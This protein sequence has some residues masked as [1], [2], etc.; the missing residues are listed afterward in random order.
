M[1][2]AKA[3]RAREYLYGWDTEANRLTVAALPRSPAPCPPSPTSPPPAKSS[4]A[5]PTP[6]PP[7]ASSPS[8]PPPLPTPTPTAPQLPPVVWR[9]GTR[10]NAPHLLAVGGPASGKTTLL[11]T[12]AVQ[13][14]RDGDVLAVDATGSGDFACLAGRAGVLRVETTQNGAREAL[15]WLR[16]ETARR[17]A[18]IAEAKRSGRAAPEDARRPLC[19]LLD[20]PAD[21]ADPDVHTLLDL[22][23]RLG[24]TTHISIV[25]TARPAQ[26]DRLHPGLLSETH[27]RVA[28]G[29]P[30]CRHPRRRPRL[31]P[32]HRRRRRRPRRPRIRPRRRRPRHPPADP[33]HPR[34]PRRRH[35]GRRPHPRPGPPAPGRGTRR[36]AGTRDRDGSHGDRTVAGEDDLTKTPS[37]ASATAPGRRHRGAPAD[38]TRST[39]APRCPR[40]RAGWNPHAIDGTAPTVVGPA[41]C[42]CAVRTSSDGDTGKPRRRLPPA[43]GAR[44]PAPPPPARR[45]GRADTRCGGGRWLRAC[46]RG[47]AGP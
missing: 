45:S 24:R 18:A 3:G 37:G 36:A 12:I 31:R 26:L 17:A 41:F 8:P 35:P 14:L 30:R 44:R 32:R 16:E 10:T 2:E 39:G 29:P 20:E 40:G 46:P 47:A 42:R 7:T 1:I 11:R 4:S 6:L 19:V 13:T 22:P 23:L 21:L 34:P 43:P 15:T 38:R 28:L 27:T 9:T 33:V 25:A 5:S